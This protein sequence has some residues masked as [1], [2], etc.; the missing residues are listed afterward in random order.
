VIFPSYS[1][2]GQVGNLLN[3]DPEAAVTA[4]EVLGP[5]RPVGKLS[6][7]ILLRGEKIYFSLFR[8]GDRVDLVEI[9]DGLQNDFM[10]GASPLMNP[11]GKETSFA[12]ETH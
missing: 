6:N 8:A 5:L 7:G 4:G 1:E 3:K 12:D 11:T 2:N 9:N 10:K